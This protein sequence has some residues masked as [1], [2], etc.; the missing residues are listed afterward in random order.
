MTFWEYLNAHDAA[1]GWVLAGLFVLAMT[2]IYE[3]WG[4]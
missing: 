2:F 4:N 1:V 3:K